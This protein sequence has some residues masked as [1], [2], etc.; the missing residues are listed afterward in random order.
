[1]KRL[2]PTLLLAPL[3][4]GC[5]GSAPPVPRDHYSRWLVPMPPKARRKARPRRAARRC[6]RA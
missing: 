3:L 4:A 5:L 6:C 2:L 1:M